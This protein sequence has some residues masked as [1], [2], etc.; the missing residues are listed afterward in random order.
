MH[1]WL[2]ILL[3]MVM[4]VGYVA[5]LRRLQRAVA[6]AQHYREELLQL[7]HDA[8]FREIM[9]EW[10]WE[11]AIALAQAAERLTNEAMAASMRQGGIDDA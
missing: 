11:E 6:E 3:V 4:V 9:A 5:L 7:G 2:L 8:T 1:E 10:Q